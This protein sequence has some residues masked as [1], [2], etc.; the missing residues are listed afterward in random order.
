[1]NNKEIFSIFN[2]KKYLKTKLT[3]VPDQLETTE[4]NI[5]DDIM[6]SLNN[7][8]TDITISE[9]CSLE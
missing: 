7:T 2:F 4:E 6:P 5:D 3:L 8:G 9:T 1:M